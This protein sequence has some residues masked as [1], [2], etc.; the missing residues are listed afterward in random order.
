MATK[1][2][3]PQIGLANAMMTAALRSVFWKESLDWV[4]GR[5]EG[6]LHWIEMFCE[7][8]QHMAYRPSGSRTN[9][10]C[11]KVENS[12]FPVCWPPGRW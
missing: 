4:N 1:E 3:S 5:S 9:S 11:V 8:V 2:V 12:S 10:Q 6:L 7:V